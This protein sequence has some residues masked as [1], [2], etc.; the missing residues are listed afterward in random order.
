M[1]HGV[2]YKFMQVQVSSLPE[3]K[4]INIVILVRGLM[5][6]GDS[7]TFI[8]WV[9]SLYFS[10]RKLYQT[11]FDNKFINTIMNFRSTQFLVI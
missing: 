5:I 3:L 1:L 11:I 2:G 6:S 7:R 4:Y 9:H 10:S 8:Q